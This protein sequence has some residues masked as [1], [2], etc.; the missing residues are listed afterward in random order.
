METKRWWLT[1]NS[2]SWWSASGIEWSEEAFGCSWVRDKSFLFCF[3]FFFWFVF[4]FLFWAQMRPK[5]KVWALMSYNS[6]TLIETRQ[7]WNA[8]HA[9]RVWRSGLCSVDCLVAAMA[10]FMDFIPILDLRSAFAAS[11]DESDSLLLV[12]SCTLGMGDPGVSKLS[13]FRFVFLRQRVR[14]SYY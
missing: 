11:D 4:M 13:V 14:I 7:K 2:L 10:N 1:E 8:P 3:F 9:P 12:F 5:Q 6:Y